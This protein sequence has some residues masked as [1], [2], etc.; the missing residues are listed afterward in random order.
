MKE[1]V[2][3][4]NKH[5]SYLWC[6]AVQENGHTLFLTEDGRKT[7]FLN[8]DSLIREID[9]ESMHKRFPDAACFQVTEVR[10]FKTHK[11]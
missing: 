6:F 2:R 4:P 9:V 11:F 10:T 7:I 5:V 3:K 1:K 8:D